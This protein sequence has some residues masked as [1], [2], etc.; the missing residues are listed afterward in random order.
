[1]AVAPWN[2]FLDNLIVLGV[3]ACV[4][5]FQP[6]FF[7]TTDVTY[8]FAVTKTPGKSAAAVESYT[9]PIKR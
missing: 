1:M 3:T 9:L 7:M 5:I 8:L 2:E 4:S 6:Y